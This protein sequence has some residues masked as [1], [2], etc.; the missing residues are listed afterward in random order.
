MNFHPNEVQRRARIAMMV[1]QGLVLVLV[2]AFFRTQIVQ[3][4]RYALAAEDNRLRQIPLPAARAVIFDR[5]GEI[6]AENV[7]G[8]SISVLARSERS[9]RELMERISTLSPV[10]PEQ[11][12]AAIRRYRT[13]PSRPTVLFTDAPPAL[14][15]MLEERRVTFP[16][17]IVQSAPKRFYPDGPVVS[18]LVGYTG[19]VNDREL[20]DSNFADYKPG[21]LIG[22]DGIERQYEARLRGREGTRF[23]EVDARGRIVRPVARTDQIPESLEPLRTN[24]DLDLQR[25]V[26]SIFGDSLIGGVVVME[27]STGAVLALH[28]APTFDPNRFTGGIP[29][30]YWD[31]LQADPR[32]PLY[33]KAIKGTYPPGSIWK[34]ATAII[35]ME[36]GLVDIDDRMPVACRG[37]YQFGTR[38]FGCW[39]P[40]G[41]GNPTLAQ[42]IEHSCDTYFYQLG[43]K[44]GLQRL[45]TGGLALGSR[46]RSGIDLPAES[47]PLFPT[48]PAKAYYDK[49]FGPQ[50]WTNAVTLNLSI[51]QGENSQTVVSMARFYTALATDGRAARPEVVQRASERE[52]LFSLAPRQ[53]QALQTALTSV[54]GTGT[55]AASRIQGI[56]VA[57]KTGTA[58]NAQS[59]DQYHAWFVGYAPAEAPQ[60]VVA[61]MLEFGGHGSRAARI[62]TRI[63]EHYLKG[64]V[65]AMPEMAGE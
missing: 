65:V 25:F 4:E 41:H 24:I 57:G 55:A 42:A 63:M 61:V 53:M 60:L 38:F 23:M 15:A 26:A 46:T 35:A 59:K 51:G 29:K 20:A 49:R 54:V 39:D 31:Q 27:P 48:D 58:Q 11:V 5:R 43:L 50:G 9:I 6:I 21:Q 22:K 64:T 32:R 28:S 12:G 19:E 7:P 52:R 45:I 34:L 10:T 33:N 44:V 30:S 56:T 37:G 14:V 16:E 3:H 1:I 40:K 8:Y 47:R 2:L 13:D 18:A 17:L 62:A 36:Q